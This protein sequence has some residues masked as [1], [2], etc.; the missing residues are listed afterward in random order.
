MT[1]LIASC[2]PTNNRICN[3]RLLAA[4]CLLF[5]SL[6]F[7]VSCGRKG[8][9]TLKAYEKPQAPS[10]LRAIHKEGE[11]ILSWSYPDHLRP[12][13]KGFQILRSA[14]NVFESIA[15]VENDRSIFID[16][17]FALDVT[18]R[19]KVIARSLKGVLSSDPDIIVVTLR[20]LPLPPENIRSAITSDAIELSWSGSVEGVCYNIYK[21]ME[22]GKYPETPLNKE[23]SCTA[24]FRDGVL[25]PDR[26]VYY[27]VRALLNT[28]IRDEG[29][30]SM[31]LEVSPSQFVP[32]PPS[33]LRVVR[34]DEKIYLM[35][36]ES[37][38]SWVRGYRIYRKRE[39][40]AQFE[41][42]GEV[43]MPAY[44]DAVNTGKKIRYVIKAIGPSRESG[45]LE[46]G[47]PE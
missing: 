30:G 5:L 43:K 39:G 27:L 36:K 19:Y 40:E 31:E 2:D 4:Y 8:P 33:D 34:A 24:S 16:N 38:E 18:Y 45:P 15:F 9:P 32:S 29:Y 1:E 44:I 37:P 47:A 11:L 35:W 26:P 21:T 23:P 46:A 3:F 14:D 12:G 28:N 17:A 13:L 25:F 20:P 10:A 41:S 6:L 22:K 7:L 42:I